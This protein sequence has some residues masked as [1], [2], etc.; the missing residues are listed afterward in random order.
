MKTLFV[1]GLAGV[2]TI[3]CE[4]EK[5]APPPA[6]TGAA[7]ATAAGATTAAVTTVATAATTP[8]GEVPAEEDF[9]ARAEATIS[10]A[11]A[12]QELSKLEK[13]IGPAQ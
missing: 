11:N 1:V 12:N 7:A 9:E 13:E 6:A 2:L 3:G 5:P 4:G 10:P 8:G